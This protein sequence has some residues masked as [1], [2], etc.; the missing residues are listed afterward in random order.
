MSSF[1]ILHTSDWHLGCRLLN[2]DRDAE[3]ED[4]LSWLI[5]IVEEQKINLLIVAG[6]IFDT[7]AP[8]NSARR[9]YYSFLRNLIRTGCE[10]VVIVGGN[11]DSPSMLEAP[12]EILELLHIHVTGAAFA[13][14]DGSIDYSKEIVEIRDD[15]NELKAVL[16]SVPFLRDRDIMKAIAGQ[17]YDDR[18]TTMREGLKEHYNKIAELLKE[19]KDIPRIVT[20][21]L[22]AE[23][24]ILPG[25]ALR[26]EG[27][28]D[29]HIGNLA[30]VDMSLFQ[31]MFTY[32]ALG[33]IHK[34]Q[35]LGNAENV[36]YSGSLIPM[37][38]SEREDKKTVTV[39]DFDQENIEGINLIEVPETR[40]I[41]R[42]S[43]T[44]SLVKAEVS[45]YINPF[46]RE[47]WGELL[48][49]ESASKQDVEEIKEI[50]K[51]RKL[52]IL[53]YGFE[54]PSANPELLNEKT[55]GK[56]LEDIT[57]DEIFEL[58][59]IEDNLT[60]E[61]AEEVKKTFTELKS[62]INNPKE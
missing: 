10:H 6:D 47:A 19:Y 27:E 4:M 18:I 56:T 3:Q 54:I 20:G 31:D 32:I 30:Q 36:R 59:C 26:Q 17:S 15:K 25:N 22:F 42:F 2:K 43:G 38:F 45:T 52:E 24:T 55:A 14:E 53:K 60:P 7:G 12:K 44:V 1:K 8:A 34:S 39:I 46:E 48:F 62:M 9:L 23:K 40:K 41:H 5:K 11:H 21:H 57:V 28:N 13:D 37:S 58:K 35:A 50:A 16:G 51:E 33:H 29:I 49:T 61:K